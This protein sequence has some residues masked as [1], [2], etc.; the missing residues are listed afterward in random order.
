MLLEI[1]LLWLCLLHLVL[2]LAIN[3]PHTKNYEY[4]YKIK[5]INVFSMFLVCKMNISYVHCKI[6]LYEN[7]NF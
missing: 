4:Q 1:K 5:F 3:R 7:Y 2:M 6:Y